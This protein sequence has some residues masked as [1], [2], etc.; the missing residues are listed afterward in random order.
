MPTLHTLNGTVCTLHL[1][2][3]ENRFDLD[4]VAAVHRALDELDAQGAP[5]TL[6]TVADGKYWSTGLDLDWIGANPSRLNDLMI[7]THELFARVLSLPV[8]TIAAVQ[9]HAFAAGAMLALAHDVRVMR[10]DRGYFCLPEVDL[11]LPFTPGMNALITA[12]LSRPTAH[13]A[14]L[15]GRRYGGE[16]A[17]ELGLVHAATSED[18][19]LPTALELAH[20]I[21]AKDATTLATIKSRLFGDTLGTLR[22]AALNTV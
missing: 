10:A 4:W 5:R 7:A 20:A 21:G 9:G 17:A 6:I 1:G 16:R 2:D 12:R 11:G 19:L 3:A 22:D 15:T 13:E 8:V 18:G 14:M